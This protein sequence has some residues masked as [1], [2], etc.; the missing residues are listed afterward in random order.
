M[1]QSFNKEFYCREPGNLFELYCE[2]SPGDHLI[3]PHILKKYPETYKNEEEL[4]NLPKFTFPC[5]LDR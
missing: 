3:E 2:V 4:K 1:I 5:P